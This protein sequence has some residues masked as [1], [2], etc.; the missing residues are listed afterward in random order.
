MNLLFTNAGRRTYMVE[1][2]LALRDAF[3][4]EV[5]VSDLTLSTAAMWVDPRVH[6][7][8]TPRVDVAPDAYAETLLHECGDRGIDI[9]IPLMDY[10]LPVLA[11]WKERF[12][13]QGITM[14]VSSPDVID[15]TLDKRT[16]Y[17]FCDTVGLPTPQ[18]WYEGQEVELSDVPLILK[19]IKGSGSVGLGI[20][21]H[22][23]AIPER[24]PEGFLMQQFVEGVEFGMDILNDLEGRF[25]HSCGRRKIAMR[26]GETDKAEVVFAPWM[27]ALARQVSDAF[28]HVGNLDLDL[29]RTPEGRV[30]F[31]DFNPRFGG[32]YPFTYAAGF[33]YLRTIL[34]I[35]ANKPIEPL[36]A[37]GRR[38]IGAKGIS[39]MYYEVT[40]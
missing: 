29:I 27:D 31:I 3:D 38:I 16:C 17:A 20:I 34:A 8:V 32:G 7:F 28:G 18:S 11:R 14:V 6:R 22:R 12:T 5:H 24:V 4:M 30:C 15:R 36:P 25:V 39:V 33:D 35:H 19:R 37:E 21:E 2:A 1:Y 13:E 40:P 26:A 10:E 9:V 23:E